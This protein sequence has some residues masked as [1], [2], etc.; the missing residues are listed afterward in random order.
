MALKETPAGA[1]GQDGLLNL[2]KSD[3]DRQHLT[4]S[5]SIYFKSAE[6]PEDRDQNSLFN[7]TAQNTSLDFQ[8]A[9]NFSCDQQR[10]SGSN[11]NQFHASFGAIGG[12]PLDSSNEWKA[13]FSNTDDFLNELNKAEQ[14]NR[15][16]FASN[17]L[18]IANIESSGDE[19]WWNVEMNNPQSS[20]LEVSS[21]SNYSS[22]EA[23]T[24]VNLGHSLGRGSKKQPSSGQKLDLES[25]SKKLKPITSQPKLH[26]SSSSLNGT[27]HHQRKAICVD[28]Y[29][30]KKS[31]MPLYLAEKD[32]DIGGITAT[33]LA[34]SLPEA[35]RYE[36]QDDPNEM[37]FCEDGEEPMEKLGKNEVM[38]PTK[39]TESSGNDTTDDITF[40]ESRYYGPDL[41]DNFSFTFNSSETGDFLL[42]K[43][44]VPPKR[45]KLKAETGLGSRQGNL[46]TIGKE[47]AS[48]SNRLNSNKPKSSSA[49]KLVSADE[50]ICSINSFESDSSKFKVPAAP[51]VT[52]DQSKITKDKSCQKL[53]K[54]PSNSLTSTPSKLTKSS[55]NAPNKNASQISVSDSSSLKIESGA[56]QIAKYGNRHQPHRDAD[57][58]SDSNHLFSQESFISSIPERTANDSTIINQNRIRTHHRSKSLKRQKNLETKTSAESSIIVRAKSSRL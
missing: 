23:M 41:S 2:T 36:A 52:A 11:F 10:V 17:E 15:Q 13:N 47:L 27:D 55:N 5:S 51:S 35:A 7:L 30:N 54:M 37:T 33:P 25:P 32:S 12:A 45:S 1:R 19:N 20:K 57:G 50:T 31:A 28:E 14:V 8:S 56:P 46:D 53:N 42:K 49:S 48:I 24:S 6:A 43:G 22:S 4:L 44:Q 26:T 38:R 3:E 34:K 18:T 21:L 40:S 58:S 29:F 9:I 16:E 39:E